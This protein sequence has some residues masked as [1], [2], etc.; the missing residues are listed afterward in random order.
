MLMATT[1]EGPQQQEMS[2]LL[3]NSKGKTFIRRNLKDE[4]LPI[5]MK[6]SI[7]LPDSL[8]PVDV[9]QINN[10]PLL[11]TDI[12]EVKLQRHSGMRL[13]QSTIMC[14]ATRILLLL[15]SESHMTKNIHV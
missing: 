6:D 7:M 12:H 4:R 14:G 10:L 2:R 8:S 1:A 13:C 3:V 5:N 15:L 11:L 9:L